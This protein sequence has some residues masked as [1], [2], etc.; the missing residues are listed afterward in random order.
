MLT[1]WLLACNSVHLSLFIFV[2]SVSWLI[3]NN[4]NNN[5]NVSMFLAHTNYSLPLS[6]HH[7]YVFLS[8]YIIY[9]LKG[10][11]IVSGNGKYQKRSD[12]NPQWRKSVVKLIMCGSIPSLLV[13]IIFPLCNTTLWCMSVS[14]NLRLA[15]WLF[16]FAAWTFILFYLWIIFK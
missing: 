7:C 2:T 13:D 9:S 14:R 4:N 15:V 8:D 10:Y 1:S 6:D 16:I 3:H 5:N 11:V 12:Y